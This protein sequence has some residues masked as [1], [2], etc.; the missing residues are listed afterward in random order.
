MLG[1]GLKD[2][3][4]EYSTDGAEWVVL[5]DVQLAQATAKSDYMANSTVAFGGVAAKFVRLIVNSGYGPMGQFG[6]SE[7]RFMQIPAHARDPQP[8]D[9]A[10]DVS[11]ATVLT[12]RAGREVASHVVS[13]GTDPDALAPAGTAEVPSFDPGTLDL[14]TMYYWQVDEV[15]ETEAISSW[16]GDL[17]SFSTQEYIVVDDFESY[18]DED[19]RIFDAWLDGFVNGTGSTVGY[20][21]APFAET[22]I[23]HGGG[24][25]MPL[26]YDNAGV[27]TSEAEF[28]LSQD[29]TA[30]GI[31]SLSLYFHGA[32]DNGGQLYV[33]INDTAVA[34]DGAATDIAESLW[35]PWNIDLSAL[36]GNLSS[37]TTL[38]I[39]IEGAGASGVVYFDDIRLYPQTPEFVVPTEPDEAGLV[40]HYAFDS[41]LNDAAG[42]HPGTAMGDA[43]LAAD[44]ARGQVLLLD[45]GG[46]AV[47]VAYSAEL[48]PEAFTACLWANPDPAG[49][50]YRSPLT[51]RDDGPQRGYIL[52]L[53]PGN[54]W[55]FWTGTGA[56]WDNTA[57]PAA[58]LGEWTHLAA[59]SENEE[60]ALY[61][62][63]RLVAQGSAP[64]G[65]N[66]ARPLRIGGGATEGPGNYF[67][68]G[69]LDEVRLYN[70]ALSPEEVA[71]LA[72]RT[73]PLHKPL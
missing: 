8:T 7:V 61:V 18:D 40:A 52:Y 48:N 72:G 28:E 53:T 64:L 20:F 37:V 70:Q 65:L 6:L 68:Q 55:Q 34:Y 15:N 73:E 5:G 16:E 35:M 21:E 46:D 4:V 58:V 13:L 36:G 66:T 49:S 23:V 67:F 60:K 57:G 38:T 25:A 9:G 45:G 14:G 59:T 54:T 27:A 62:N 63:G 19:N 39:G 42:A 51:S 10:T 43:Q 22:V 69:M 30:S 41:D 11:V 71:G 2:V 17:W 26:F 3:T 24:Q 50:N 32:P 31:K 47:E 33:K 56:G 1:F 12:W 44:P 29:W